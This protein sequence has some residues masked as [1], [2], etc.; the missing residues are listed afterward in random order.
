MKIFGYEWD[1]IRRAQ[2]RERGAL[3]KPMP[4]YD[5]AKRKAQIESDM[6]KFKIN[7]DKATAE[8]L[9]ITI[10][11]GYVLIGETYKNVDTWEN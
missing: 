8:A 1:D 10:P 2:Q 4:P 9:N 11:E 5:P 3:S 7:V 6:K